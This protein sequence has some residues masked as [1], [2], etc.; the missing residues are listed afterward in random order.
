MSDLLMESLIQGVQS[1]GKGLVLERVNRISLQDFTDPASSKE[2]EQRLAA[3]F[4]F[5]HD[6]FPE[7]DQD[8]DLMYTAWVL[9]VLS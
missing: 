1:A 9:V 5:T 2:A 4:V 3:L 6:D 8:L 7:D